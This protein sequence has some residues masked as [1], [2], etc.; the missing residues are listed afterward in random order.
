MIVQ[1]KQRGSIGLSIYAFG[2]TPYSN[3]KEDEIATQR[4]KDFLFGWLVNTSYFFFTIKTKEM[5][6]C[7]F[8]NVEEKNVNDFFEFD[9]PQDV[10]AF[11]VWGLSRC[12]E[13]S[14]GTEVTCFLRGRVRA[15]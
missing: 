7:C 11:G 4:A 10:E 5:F 13:E 8:S 1:S 2:L 9:N 15:S 6:F 3:S 12:N 14:F